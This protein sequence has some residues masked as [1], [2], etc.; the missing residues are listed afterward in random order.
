[1]RRTQA[2]A[3]AGDADG[4]AW[5][6]A[7]IKESMRLHPVIP[8]VVR[9]LMKPPTIAGID[10]PRGAT[11]GP[12][13]LIAHRR[14]GQLRRTPSGSTPSGSS[15]TTR[16]PTP[17]SRSAAASAAAS[18]PASR[19]MEGVAVLREVF[20]AVD[21]TAV[22]DRRAEVRNITSVPREAARIRVTPVT[23][24]VAST[25]DIAR[26]ARR[27]TGLP[28]R[29]GRV[30]GPSPLVTW[31]ERLR[32]LRMDITPLR[33]SRDFRLLFCAGTVFYF[34]AMVSY[35]AIP[36]QIYT[37]TGSNFAVG[38]IGLVELVP[39]IVFG[40][41]GGAL[42]DHVDRR[43]LLVGLRPRPGAFTGGARGQRVPRRPQRLADLRGQRRPGLDVVDAAAAAARR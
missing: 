32:A 35:V 28:A 6:D 40:L 31:G 8:M 33:T 15:A 24:A 29:R 12:S 23:V 7:V 34:G 13:I 14:D 20:R 3:D 22:G 11:V 27:I 17:G 42:A 21:V 26:F 37:L 9:T 1:M 18:A 38:A 16:R 39:L 5:L 41:Y 25:L 36:Y 2:A 43:K 19:M 10:L 30:P 4:D